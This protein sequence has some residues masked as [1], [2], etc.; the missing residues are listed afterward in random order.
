MLIVRV[1]PH[2]LI[3]GTVLGC[4]LPRDYAAI[5]RSGGVKSN[6]TASKAPWPSMAHGASS[7]SSGDL[8]MLSC[9][10]RA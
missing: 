8:Q 6:Q 10:S 5:T 9:G 3:L 1:D 2:E 4:H 7:A